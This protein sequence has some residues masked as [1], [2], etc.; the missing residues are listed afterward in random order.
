MGWGEC[1]A[2]THQ[3]SSLRHE[4]QALHLPRGASLEGDHTLS[5]STRG[6]WWHYL[7]TSFFA[8]SYIFALVVYYSSVHFPTSLYYSIRG[9]PLCWGV[10]SAR[11]G[12]RASRLSPPPVQF[13]K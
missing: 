4:G 8:L 7:A 3:G 11:R 13:F 12:L 2:G 9:G 1:C 5:L 10:E 6:A